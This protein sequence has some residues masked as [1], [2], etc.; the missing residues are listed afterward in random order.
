M[1]N[2][3]PYGSIGNIWQL[4]NPSGSQF[5]GGDISQLPDW[6]K[7]QIYQQQFNTGGDGGQTYSANTIG[8]EAGGAMLKDQN[9][10][11]VVQ[12]GDPSHLMNQPGKSGEWLIDPSKVTYDPNLGYVTDPN[13]I[14]S[15]N[16]SASWGAPVA[17]ALLT[18]GLLDAGGLLGGITGNTTNYFS[19]A[20]GGM[21]PNS[22]YGGMLAANTTDVPVGELP[23]S[24]LEGPGVAGGL[25]PETA[26]GAGGM[27]VA[28]N[29]IGPGSFMAQLQ[30]AIANPGS[31]LGSNGLLANGGS[32]LLSSALS[33]PIQALGL[34]QMGRGLVGSHGST[35]SS[36]SGSSKP[37]GGSGVPAPQQRAAWTPNPYTQSQIHQLY[38]V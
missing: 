25:D 19:G 6:V 24:G 18:G 37:Q 22:S 13:N 7:Q 15:K 38:G 28:Q 11:S 10:N 8:S 4:L 34:L 12:I 1:S 36:T 3:N 14:G 29:G 9:G 16:A 17:A 33:N 26:A 27:S 23:Y 32:S 31:L 2:Q 35:S 21:G 30:G 5:G 20:L